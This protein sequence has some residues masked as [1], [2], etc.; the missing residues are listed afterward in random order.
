MNE[1]IIRMY[2][3]HFGDAILISIPDEDGGNPKMRHILID[4]GNVRSGAGGLNEVFE[5]AINDIL[6]VLGDEPLDLYIMTHE[7]LDHVQGLLWSAKGMFDYENGELKDKLKVKHAWL[8]IS[9]HPDYYNTHTEAKKKFDLAS[10]TYHQIKNFAAISPFSDKEQLDIL[11]QNNDRFVPFDAQNLSIGRTADCVEYLRNLA[12]ETHYVHRSIGQ[13]SGQNTPV[14]N[15]NDTHP[16]E[17]IDFEIWAPE[18]N[19]ADYYGRF[20][21]MSLGMVVSRNEPPA[22]VNAVPP[23]GVEANAFYNLINFRKGGLLDNLLAI[24]K[25]AN[26]SSIVFCLKWKNW[27]F[28]FPGDAEER[29]WKEMN[30]ENVLSPVDFLKI[31]HHGSHNG[32]PAKDILEKI[33]PENGPNRDKRQAAV[34]TFENTYNGIPHGESFEELEALGC[35]IHST[36][37]VESGKALE[38]RFSA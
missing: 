33:F 2:N 4:V 13:P 26:N 14:F 22:L 15:L 20:R 29:S 24:D 19:S 32:T 21:P 38:M 12:D 23:A 31:S 25:A 16:F 28:L 36:L 9:A 35:T 5:P 34:S 11:L 8:P 3:V 30:K 17:T 27:R 18:E 1:L 6:K 37:D 10:E 7:H